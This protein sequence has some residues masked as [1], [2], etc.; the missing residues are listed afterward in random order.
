MQDG[1]GDGE[2]STAWEH[3]EVDC[4]E[5]GLV[6]FDGGTYSRGPSSLVD[7]GE[8]GADDDESP[9]EDA[10]SGEQGGALDADRERLER[11][12]TLQVN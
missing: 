11:Q 8:G 6:Y 1:N 9:E 3:D 10:G 7:A 4:D 2:A 12:L 5:D